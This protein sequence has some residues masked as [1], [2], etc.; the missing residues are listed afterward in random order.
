MR[1]RIGCEVD[2]A[3][4]PRDRAAQTAGIARQ[5]WSIGEGPVSDAKLSELFQI[6]KKHVQKA[7][8]GLGVPMAAGFRG[9]DGD[10]RLKVFLKRRHRTSRRFALARLVGDHLTATEKEQILP[11][12]E[13]KTERQQFQRAFSQEFLCPFSELAEFL[14]QR[15][16]DPTDDAIEDAADHFQVSPLLVKT[17]LVNRGL[18]DRGVLRG[19]MAA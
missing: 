7:D 8:D 10:E 5:I 16:N 17:T 6:P 14:G 1:E 9:D 2:P 18:M 11:A 12:T 4:Y 3:A 15:T 13:A 19:V